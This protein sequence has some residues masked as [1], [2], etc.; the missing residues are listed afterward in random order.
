MGLGAA[1]A[2]E[3]RGERAAD[4]DRKRFPLHVACCMCAMRPDLRPILSHRS[5]IMKQRPGL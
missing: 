1:D 2:D 5:A 3:R 4:A